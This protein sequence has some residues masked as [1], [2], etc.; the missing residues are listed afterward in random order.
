MLPPKNALLWPL[1]PQA[2]PACLSPLLSGNHCHL[3][4][5][6]SHWRNTPEDLISG[7][8][9]V[10]VRH[11]FPSCPRTSQGA[12]AT[13][14]PPSGLAWVACPESLEGRQLAWKSNL[15]MST[16]SRGRSPGDGKKARDKYVLQRALM[17]EIQNRS[18]QVVRGKAGQLFSVRLLKL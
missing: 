16:H 15:Q 11:I 8:G 12:A 4:P 1:G 17:S 9:R 3:L 14:C 5:R 7:M 10:M 2:L 13:S 6:G 18:E